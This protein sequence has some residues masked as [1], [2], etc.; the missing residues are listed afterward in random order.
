M[1]CSTWVS[2]TGVTD[3]Q[4]RGWEGNRGPYRQNFDPLAVERCRLFE[5]GKV[6]H[7]RLRAGRGIVQAG[8]DHRLGEFAEGYC[9]RCLGR[10]AI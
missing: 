1:P 4:G 6:G 10:S 7:D 9:R 3:A 5:P 8:L 2:K